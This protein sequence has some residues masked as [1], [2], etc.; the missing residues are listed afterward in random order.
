MRVAIFAPVFVRPTETFIFDTAVSLL[1]GGAD[2]TVLTLRREGSRPF[3]SIVEL[4]PDA[5]HGWSRIVAAAGRR[6]GLAR[7]SASRE[8]QIQRAIKEA[9]SALRPDVVL[10]NY[11]HGG[12]LLAP[13]AHEL[14]IPMVVS[15][16][17]ADASRRASK[18]QWQEKYR[19]LFENCALVTGPSQYVVD[20]LV[21]MGC[22]RNQAKVLHYGINTDRLAATCLREPDQTRPV[23][24]LFVGRL[25][26][27]KD[28]VGLLES[29]R[30]CLDTLGPGRATLTMIGDGPLRETVAEAANRLGLGAALE[31]AG[32]LP[33]DHVLGAYANAD[34][35]VQHSVVAPDGDSE[36]LPVSITEALAARLPVIATR[37]SGIPEVVMDGQTGYLVEERDYRAMGL[38]MADLAERPETWSTLGNAGQQLLEAEFA[39]PVVRTELLR[40]LAAAAASGQAG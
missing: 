1:D 37:H 31:L 14:G 10:A 30:I 12:V 6:L 8:A 35:Y 18:P 38:R 22:P 20:R 21:A 25:T 28:P 34:I 4:N 33:H 15:F 29:F 36:G 19:N 13:I 3:P 5:R 39:I 27:K 40:I 16:H 24:F 9:L 26:A 32:S 11:G 23:H 7:K 2:V 17:G